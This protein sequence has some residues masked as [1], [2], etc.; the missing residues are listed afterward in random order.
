MKKVI[1]IASTGGHLNELLQLAPCFKKYDYT[2]I[3]EKT[4]SNVG[5]VDKHPGRIRFLIAGT[6]TTLGAKLLYPFRFLGNCVKS[7]WFFM[8]IK[9]DV[10]VTTGTHNAVPMCYIAHF[11]K[12]KVIFIETFA[13]SSSPT[14]SG[15]MVYK[16]AD[17]FVVQWESMKEFYPDA[18]YGGWIY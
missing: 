7:L 15:R 4:K 2:L 6:Y 16:V 17:K 18:I 13:N 9:P 8:K 12:K 3:T 1:F 10:V 14:K 11:F 5:L